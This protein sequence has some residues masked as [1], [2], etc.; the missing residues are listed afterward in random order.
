[1]NRLY[2]TGAAVAFGLAAYGML[3]IGPSP[4][5]DA[6]AHNSAVMECADYLGGIGYNSPKIPAACGEFETEFSNPE[7][8]FTDPAAALDPNYTY[9]LPSHDE[10]VES[11]LYALDKINDEASYDQSA[12]LVAS[13]ILG[14]VAYAGIRTVRWCRLN[15]LEADAYDQPKRQ[16]SH[17]PKMRPNVQPNE[18]SPEWPW[19][20]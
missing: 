18:D 8:I 9:F 7:L 4:A 6:A 2:D 3:H 20:P 11:E 12:K 1:M 10:F 17:V 16:V 13:V 15:F 5:E 14:G 19:V